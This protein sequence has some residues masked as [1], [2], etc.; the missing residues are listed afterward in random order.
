MI[1]ADSNSFEAQTEKVRALGPNAIMKLFESLKFKSI[2]KSTVAFF[3]GR[4]GKA[5]LALIVLLIASF[6]IWRI[7]QQAYSSLANERELQSHAGIIPCEKRLR[8]PLQTKAIKQI[9]SARATRGLM[10]WGE[11]Y[12]AATEGG[13][14]QLSREGKPQRIYTTLDGLTENDL[15]A[16]APFSSKVFIGTRTQ[17]LL[18][19]DGEHFESYAWT[20][21]KAETITTLFEDKGRLLIGTFA[22]GLI[23]FDG[24][25]FRELKAGPEQKRL[26]AVTR[27]VRDEARLYI[28]TFADGLWV[29]GAGR[30]FHF[31]RNDGLPSNRIVE[32]VTKGDEV[33]VAT[34]FGLAMVQSQSLNTETSQ[35]DRFHILTT[36]PTLSGVASRGSQ[37]L[38]STDDG[39]VFSFEKRAREI[40]WN[41]PNDL[42]ECVFAKLD[43][44]LLLLS[45]KGI[46]RNN[47]DNAPQI[48][49]AK[50]SFAPFGKS[51][52]QTL[53]SNA[54][55]SLAFDSDGR[56]WAGSFRNGL[57]VFD[58]NGRKLSHIE[59]ESAREINAVVSDEATKSV[60]AATSQGVLRFDASFRSTQ[61]T[62]NEGLLSNSVQHLVLVQAQ[63]PNQSSATFAFAT[64]RGLSL[65]T[66]ENL[67]NLTTVQGLPNNNTYA[68]FTRGETLF[69]GTLG[70]LAQ[71]EKGKVVR[72][73]KDSNSKLTHNWV[74]ALAGAGPHIFIGTYGGGVFEL[75]TSGE[76]RSFA[77][78]T[79]KFTVNPNA[80]W[81]DG[82]R[83]YVGTLEGAWVFNLR[84]QKWRHIQDELPSQT[85]LSVTC[86][87]RHVYVGTTSGIARIEKKYFDEEL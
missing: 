72:T 39:K 50:L 52:E 53:T 54:I 85:V 9:N 5:L 69:L 7:R 8:L 6:T 82:E 17:G 57:D 78:E 23:E 42:S 74:T 44:E 26:N 55:S 48:E 36:L 64:S 43:D 68:V 12:Y 28:G 80:M 56:L 83:L 79:G 37:L 76:L 70:G 67:R 2:L 73:F 31:T 65:G 24:Q 15:T 3:K 4:R 38:L 32:V 45:N 11:A 33:F 87:A 14:V 30:W 1:F 35:P 77:S 49:S 66:K 16:I 41:R 22:G 34:D 62:K 71:I 27:I 20:D 13:L 84:S 47:I 19:F 81:T 86:D 51:N 21:R 75:A 18:S 25:T 58:A 10:R 63:K 60:Y 61:I 29:E 46:W 40:V 59:S